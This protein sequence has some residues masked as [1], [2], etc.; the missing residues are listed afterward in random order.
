MHLAVF[1]MDFIN[2]KMQFPEN[3]LKVYAVTCSMLAGI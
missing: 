2:S 1:Y 3:N